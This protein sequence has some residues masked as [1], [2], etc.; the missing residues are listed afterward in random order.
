MGCYT[1]VHTHTQIHTKLAKLVSEEETLENYKLKCD[2]SVSIDPAI[3]LS[4]YSS[5]PAFALSLSV[6]THT[7]KHTQTHIYTNKIYFNVCVPLLQC[8]Y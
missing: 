4:V 6:R 7:Q 1:C 3:V 5:S 8:C 2:L